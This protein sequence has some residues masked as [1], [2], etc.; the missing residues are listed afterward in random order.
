MR[1]IVSGE[2]LR[3]D[4]GSVTMFSMPGTLRVER[5]MDESFLQTIP[6][7]ELV[8]CMEE[9]KVD[10]VQAGV[11]ILRARLGKLAALVQAGMVHIQVSTPCA[12]TRVC[13]PTCVLCSRLYMRAELA[14]VHTCSTCFV[15][16]GLFKPLVRIIVH[17]ILL[18][19]EMILR[20][21]AS[22]KHKAM[23]AGWRSSRG[24]RRWSQLGERCTQA[25]CPQHSGAAL[26]PFPRPTR[27]IW[28]LVCLCW[29]SCDSGERRRGAGVAVLRGPR[30]ACLHLIDAGRFVPRPLHEWWPIQHT[31]RTPRIAC[32]RHKCQQWR[33]GEG[34]VLAVVV[35]CV[36]CVLLGAGASRQAAA[37]CSGPS[38]TAVGLSFGCKGQHGQGPARTA[39]HF[40]LLP[41]AARVSCCAAVLWAG[42]LTALCCVPRAVCF[43]CVPRAVCF[44][45]VPR[46]VCF[47]CV[48]CGAPH[49]RPPGAYVLYY[50][51]CARP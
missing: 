23:L 2:V 50:G 33:P 19:L 42:W 29:R 21:S 28:C 24:L 47:C 15:L 51:I 20:E 46:A 9:R 7:E 10:P 27:A 31:E 8:R 13:K 6:L 17:I 16:S 44:C 40:G 1:Y 43:C 25:Q 26:R 49:L 36:C 22:L 38:A 14:P 4:V 48:P 39:Q 12:C 5:S 18:F 3:G 30:R 45:C 35:G 41:F 11:D 37:S 34:A 32:D